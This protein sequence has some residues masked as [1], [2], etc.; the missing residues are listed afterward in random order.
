MNGR[1]RRRG[2][3][4]LRGGGL[5][6][7]RPGVTVITAGEWVCGEGGR[8]SKPLKRTEREMCQS[9][10]T[11]HIHH[12]DFPVRSEAVARTQQGVTIY[13]H[14]SRHEHFVGSKF[15]ACT[16]KDASITLHSVENKRAAVPQPFTDELDCATKNLNSLK[17]RKN[18]SLVVPRPHR[19]PVSAKATPLAPAGVACDRVA[20]VGEVRL[21]GSVRVQRE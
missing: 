16:C 20:L 13:C 14:S 17:T 12:H 21:H 18:D 11:Q 6:A 9:L 15:D 2:G 3:R 7:R 4:K 10:R 5:R 8:G 19:K 1:K